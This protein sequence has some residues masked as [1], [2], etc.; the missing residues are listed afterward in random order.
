VAYIENATEL[1][2]SRFKIQPDDDLILIP[3][4]LE[5]L[6]EDPEL[7]AALDALTPGSQRGY[8]L[9]FGAAKQAT[10]RRSRI[11]KAKPK[12]LAGKGQNER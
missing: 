11:E 4:L 2:K 5:K 1:E 8:N 12:I 10:T 6:A 3:E 7:S 9:C